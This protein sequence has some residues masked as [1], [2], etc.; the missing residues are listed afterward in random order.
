MIRNQQEEEG[1]EEEQIREEAAAEED[2]KRK[3]FLG[4]GGRKKGLVEE[5][6]TPM[7]DVSKDDDDNN[8]DDQSSDQEREGGGGENRKPSDCA[9]AH[10]CS[11]I[12]FSFLDKTP[13]FE[14]KMFFLLP[15]KA[16]APNMFFLYHDFSN[17]AASLVSCTFLGTR[18]S[19]K[20]GFQFN[21]YLSKA[22]PLYFPFPTLLFLDVN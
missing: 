10:N 13:P 19:Y 2:M 20:L 14:R 12:N 22:S 21:R 11:A 9:I 16:S 17:Q 3:I 8:G 7:E 1:E 6:E 18:K 15:H 5:R 4:G